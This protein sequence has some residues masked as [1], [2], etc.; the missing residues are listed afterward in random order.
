MSSTRKILAFAGSNSRQS[1]NKAFADFVA[2]QIPD[3]T[4]TLADLN[5]YELPLYH[6]DLEKSL[7]VPE[8]AVDF[9]QLI[10]NSDGIVLSL[11]EHNGNQAAVFKNLWDWMSRL[12]MQVWK[13]KP[14]FLMGVSPGG[15]GAASVLNITK[16]LMPWFGGRVVAEFSLPFY[17]KNF[18]G[19]RLLDPTM[20]AALKEQVNLFQASLQEKSVLV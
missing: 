12:G 7:G 18:D 2:Q 13:D 6:P 19:E 15:R 11:A 8:N 16:T 4:V 5:D 1:I 17:Q 3:A 9:S 10:E 20:N 14:I